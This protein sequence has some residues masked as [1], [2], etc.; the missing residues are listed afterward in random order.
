MRDAFIKS[1]KAHPA[2]TNIDVASLIEEPKEEAHGDLAF[3]CFILS[4]ELKE[5]PQAIAKRLADE[6]TAEEFSFEALGPYVNARA[7]DA[8]IA[9]TGLET[10]YEKSLSGR[11]LIEYS[12]P[13]TNKPLHIGHMRNMI[14]GKA[15]ITV[16]ERA[17]ADVVP[18]VLYNDRGIA[19]CKSMIA[20][21][22]FSNS[23]TP[24]SSGEKGDHFVGRYYRMYAE[25]LEEHPELEEDAREMLRKWEAGD[26][27]VRALWKQMNEWAI[28]GFRET[29]KHFSLRYE[30]EYY[31]SD[32]YEQ[33]AALV[34]DALGKGVV[35]EDTSGIIYDREDGNA[36]TLLR[37]DGTALYITQD[38]ALLKERIEEHSPDEIVYV[39]AK[40]QAYHFETL[41]E[42]AP[43][44]GIVTSEK[45]EHYA[46]GLVTL[47]EGKMSSR[48]GRVV[49]ADDLLAETIDRARV[50]IKE[51]E[52]AISDEELEARARTIAFGALA[53][54]MVK[55][56]P[57][58]DLIYDAKA[59]MRFEGE[60]GPYV[61]YT[62]ARIRSI[63]RSTQKSDASW[64]NLEGAERVLLKA[65]SRYASVLEES[66]RRKEPSRIAHYLLNLSQ[67]FNSFYHSCKVSGS[68]HEGR[69]VVLCERTAHTLSD[70]LG[71]LGIDVLEVM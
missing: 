33:G 20:Y 42:L 65:L 34:R 12:Q 9:Q 23:E 21:E 6:L 24:E 19:I 41:F 62:Y 11:A 4:R 26:A 1:L 7:T 56:N 22:R 46:Y 29:F 64:S 38:I 71:L 66:A 58:D 70:G 54:F 51:R 13:N 28:E 15:L 50:E 68:E 57:M 55:Q 17:G 37:S 63:L 5:N 39:V 48:L 27:Q 40:E 44:L 30:K 59:A 61:Q 25:K 53:F 14:L 47:P 10:G 36:Y 16:L 8:L 69:R 35:R 32:V 3:P 60:S 49:M 18:I 45:L 2:L 43:K 67:S 31:E 52:S